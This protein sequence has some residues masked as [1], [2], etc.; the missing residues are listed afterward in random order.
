MVE[1]RINLASMPGGFRSS[2]MEV[3]LYLV[4]TGHEFVLWH[5]KH[6]QYVNGMSGHW[7]S[8]LAE[9]PLFCCDYLL[10]SVVVSGH[11]K[12]ILCTPQIR[13]LP[14][15]A[16]VSNVTETRRLAQ[17]NCLRIRSSCK[18]NVTI[19]DASQKVSFIRQKGRPGV[20]FT[21]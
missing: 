8:V 18:Q 12:T 11:V 3:V 19:T 7:W 2:V 15:C 1:P 16:H 17:P 4:T 5:V 13:P 20:F 21:T 10:Y 9:S 14:Y 6:A